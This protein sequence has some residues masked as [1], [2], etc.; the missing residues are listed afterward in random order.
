MSVRMLKTVDA[1][2]KE[3]NQLQNFVL[4]V[5]NYEVNTLEQKVLKEYAYL[6]SMSK[7]VDR[8]NQELGIDTIDKEYVSKLLQSKPIDPLHKI[9]K[10]NYL[11]KTRAARRKPNTKSYI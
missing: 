4:L 10:S 6:G 5:E 7:V 1:A 2:K 11:L 8:I 3:I 9:L